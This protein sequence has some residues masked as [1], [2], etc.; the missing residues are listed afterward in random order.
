LAGYDGVPHMFSHLYN[1]LATTAAHAR[2]QNM[3]IPSIIVSARTPSEVTDVALIRKQQGRS[4]IL[5]QRC[6]SNVIE[7]ENTK[8]TDQPQATMTF[9]ATEPVLHI[10]SGMGTSESET[11]D[12]NVANFLKPTEPTRDTQSHSF[13]KLSTDDRPPIFPD[14]HRIKRFYGIPKPSSTSRFIVTK[15]ESVYEPVTDMPVEEC[16][17]ADISYQ[18]AKS[19]C[20][21]IP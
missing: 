17:T 12:T 3:K 16:K 7:Y 15:V 19:R 10:D 6:T 1:L 13:T 20:E 5:H 2:F 14:W 11:S 21:S 8:E 4:R 18:Y 9:T